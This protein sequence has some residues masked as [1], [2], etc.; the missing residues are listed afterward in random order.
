VHSRTERFLE[1]AHGHA[2]LSA[3]YDWD[4][5]VLDAT[6]LRMVRTDFEIFFQREEWFR[7]H[8]LPYRRGYLFLGTAGQWK[9]RHSQ[10]DGG[11]SPHPPL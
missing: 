5:V 8:N 6:T 2:R 3:R 7:Q 11:A 1:T 10:S 9:E 4:S